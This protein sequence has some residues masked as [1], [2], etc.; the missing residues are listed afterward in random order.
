M[1]KYQVRVWCCEGESDGIECYDEWIWEGG[2]EYDVAKQFDSEEEA[3]DA[4]E[5]EKV[6]S[7][8]TYSGVQG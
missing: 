2:G 1:P 5:A 7:V 8:F 6:D 3:D 4:G